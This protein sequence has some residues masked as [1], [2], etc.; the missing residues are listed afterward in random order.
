MYNSLEK[1]PKL[2]ELK[3]GHI[4]SEDIL[5]QLLISKENSKLNTL[6]LEF[7]ELLN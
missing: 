7:T 3:N 4:F 1:S 5:S 2:L 6:I